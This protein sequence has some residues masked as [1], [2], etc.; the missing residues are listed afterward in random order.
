M[1]LLNLPISLGVGKEM[2]YSLLQTYPRKNILH[3]CLVL[4]VGF[5]CLFVFTVGNVFYKQNKCLPG[6]YLHDKFSALPLPWSHLTG[7]VFAACLWR[8]ELALQRLKRFGV[9]AAA[10]ICHFIC[11]PGVSSVLFVYTCPCWPDGA[12]FGCHP[13]QSIRKA[14]LCVIFQKPR[15]AASSAPLVTNSLT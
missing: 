15:S 11:Q 6:S 5:V 12:G 8:A 7:P 2:W 14:R 13:K 1:G 4:L 3:F 10:L 9:C